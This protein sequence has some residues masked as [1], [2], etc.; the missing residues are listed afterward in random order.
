MTI[1]KALFLAIIVAASSPA[2]AASGLMQGTP[3]DRAAC[4]PDVRKFCRALKPGADAF[5][6]LHCLQAH[7]SELRAV[8]RKVLETHGQ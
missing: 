4:R 2:W 8:C 3:K 5:D 1:L 7:R 6:F